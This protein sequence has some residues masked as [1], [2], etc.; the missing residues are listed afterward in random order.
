MTEF[1]KVITVTN[2]REKWPEK[3]VWWTGKIYPDESAFERE[4]YVR[5]DICDEMLEV[6]KEIKR[7]I[8]PLMY[9]EEIA[10]INEIV[11]EVEGE[12]NG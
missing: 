4:H 6:M 8:D 11:N 1:P 5:K 2:T 9:E 12:T 10:M 3:R 7:V